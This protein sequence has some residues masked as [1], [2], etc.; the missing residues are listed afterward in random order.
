[1]PRSFQLMA[2]PVTILAHL[3]FVAVTTLV[4]VWLLKFREG[5]AFDSTN[6]LKILNLH[7]FL[8]VVGFILVGGEAIM[9]FRTIPA[10]RRSKKLVH[11]L[12][13]LIALGSAIFGI[14]VIFKFKNEMNLPN[15]FT[16][17]SWFG[18]SAICA[19]GL[20]Y[21]VAF[22][23]Y[24]FPGAE[25][26]TRATLLPWHRFLGLVIF[27]LAISAAL[28]GLLERFMM[29]GLQ[30]QQEALIMNFTALLLFLFGA[31]VSLVVI[32]PRSSY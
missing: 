3:I 30:R 14:V 31:L 25:T 26:S 24:F 1:M 8:M 32:L 9:A 18:I 17:H 11:L 13:H 29:L 20:Q 21:I 12:L 7:P 27:Q 10:K 4:L 2:F 19:F 28:T 22:F 16:L 5:F 6:K 15:M 23:T